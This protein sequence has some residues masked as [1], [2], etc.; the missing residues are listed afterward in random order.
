[1][2]Y[3]AVTSLGYFSS[4]KSQ[5]WIGSQRFQH[6]DN[7]SGEKMAVLKWAYPAETWG[8][9]SFLPFNQINW[10]NLK[11]YFHYN[12]LQGECSGVIQI[13][14]SMHIKTCWSFIGFP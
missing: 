6:N 13:P 12:L 2:K 11:V 7:I 4:L 14:V 1:M 10:D 5:L 9:S 3:Y 8:I